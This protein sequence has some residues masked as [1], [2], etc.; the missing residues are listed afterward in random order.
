[1]R[2]EVAEPITLARA[3]PPIPILRGKTKM[4]SKIIFKTPPEITA[5]MANFGAP[6]LRTK[7]CKK[8]EKAKQHIPQITYGRIA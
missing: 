3:A 2:L 7:V 4:M 1:M 8:V 5:T 6:S